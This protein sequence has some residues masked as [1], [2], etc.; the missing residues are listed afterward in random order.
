MDS[1]ARQRAAP[2]PTTNTLYRRRRFQTPSPST[3][4]STDRAH[5][6]L[7]RP[8]PTP[9]KRDANSKIDFHISLRGM[10]SPSKTIPNSITRGRSQSDRQHRFRPPSS[11][12]PS[13][14]QK[15]KPS[16]PSLSPILSTLQLGKTTNQT[17]PSFSNPSSDKLQLYNGI[18]ITA[19]SPPI[20][21]NSP[22]SLLQHDSQGQPKYFLD[23]PILFEGITHPKKPTPDV[24]K[25]RPLSGKRLH[26]LTPNQKR[27]LPLPANK[28]SPDSPWSRLKSSPHHHQSR[29]A[30]PIGGSRD[31]N[32]LSKSAS[33]ERDEN[34]HRRNEDFVSVPMK[35]LSLTL[36]RDNFS[37]T[38]QITAGLRRQYSSPAL[39]SG[40]VC[41]SLTISFIVLPV[42]FPSIPS[43]KWHL[44][45][46]LFI[47]YF[48]LHLLSIF[49]F[50]LLMYFTAKLHLFFISCVFVL[51][52]NNEAI[53]SVVPNKKYLS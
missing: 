30:N 19:A 17:D 11:S 15:F 9:A 43:S 35:S 20:P 38:D 4:S 23:Q 49:L 12:R 34:S 41:T 28:L 21:G 50:F 13:T 7:P 2:S 47:L 5:S 6:V 25:N 1:W 26:P 46:P 29:D 42:F 36:G 33:E 45:C 8:P 16:T 31:E 22:S 51:I 40:M 37:S 32:R 3:I 18:P 24:A 10:S 48:L 27:T 44:S 52:V 14:P 53:R 39:S